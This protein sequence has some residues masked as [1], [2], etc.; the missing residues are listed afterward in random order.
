[1]LPCTLDV[2]HFE[3]VHRELLLVAQ[4]YVSIFHFPARLLFANH[5]IPRPHDVVDRI[6]ILQKGTQ[7]FQTIREFGGD[8][9]EINAAT[10]LKIGKLRDLKAVEHDLPSD[11]PSAERR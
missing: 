8:G 1:M 7:P 9:I 10:L 3:V 4:T 5:W 11:A 2:R 6:D